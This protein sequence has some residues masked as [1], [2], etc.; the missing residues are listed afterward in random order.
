[1]SYIAR[2]VGYNPSHPP[3]G[4]CRR[5][6]PAKPTLRGLL[7]ESGRFEGDQ[8][9]E[10]MDEFVTHKITLADLIDTGSEAALAAFLEEVVEDM[11]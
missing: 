6:E 1:M 9:T 2:Y 3:G 7:Q 10:A 5:M 4:R 8:L 11:P